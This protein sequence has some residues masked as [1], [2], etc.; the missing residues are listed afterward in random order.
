MIFGADNNNND[1]NNDD[2]NYDDNNNDGCGADERN[3]FFRNNFCICKRWQDLDVA[4]RTDF[5]IA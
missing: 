2:N 5:S 3:I 4:G 1:D